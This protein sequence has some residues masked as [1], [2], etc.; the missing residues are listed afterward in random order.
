M[1]AGQRG[2]VKLQEIRAPMAPVRDG[3]RPQDFFPLGGMGAEKV[4]TLRPY[5]S[6]RGPREKAFGNR[7]IPADSAVSGREE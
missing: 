6:C 4:S 3:A 5:G 2:R 1:V 7:E